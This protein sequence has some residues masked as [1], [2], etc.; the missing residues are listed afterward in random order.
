MNPEI[1][2]QLIASTMASIFCGASLIFWLLFIDAMSLQRLSKKP[3]I[4]SQAEIGGAV[5][6]VSIAFIF[7]ALLE[8]NLKERKWLYFSGSN[9]LANHNSIRAAK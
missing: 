4:S 3:L 2:F 7:L 8:A 1:T 9:F 5:F 6:L